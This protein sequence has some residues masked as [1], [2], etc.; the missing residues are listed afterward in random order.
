MYCILE[1]NLA[2]GVSYWFVWHGGPV[3]YCDVTLAILLV[4]G[5]MLVTWSDLPLVADCSGCIIRVFNLYSPGG[6]LY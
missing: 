4:F 1:G 2:Q 3:W 5:I 6:S